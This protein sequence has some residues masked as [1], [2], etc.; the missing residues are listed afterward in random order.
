MTES[1]VWVT[2]VLTFWALIAF[3][4]AYKSRYKKPVVKKATAEDV[5]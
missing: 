2:I 1:Q 5:R 4:D 3:I